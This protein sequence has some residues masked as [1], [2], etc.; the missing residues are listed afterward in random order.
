[1]V[2]VV[3]A[4]AINWDISL[5][6]KRFPEAGEEVEVKEIRRVSGGTAANVAVAA[7]KLLGKGKVA[8]LGALGRDEIAEKQVKILEEWGVV[9]EGLELIGEV[10]S[11]QAYIVIDEKGRNIIH[12]FF[13]A[14]LKF[15][16][17]NV[18]KDKVLKLINDCKVAVIMDPPLVT[19]LELATQARERGKKVIW[20][21]G[22]YV[23]K[24]IK[25]L[26]SVIKKVNYFVLNHL[27]YRRLLNTSSVEEIMN[28]L[29][30]INSEI[31]FI[32]KKGE[33]GASLTD[34][35]TK[36][37]VHVEGLNL[38][39]LGFK[40]V[41]TVGCGDAFIGAF[42]AAKTLDLSDEEALKWGCAA[43]AF[44]ATK[45][46]TRGSPTLKELKKFLK[47]Y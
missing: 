11:G 34:S 35:V 16:P 10:E 42:A 40:I 1:M 14:N 39:K 20:D 15:K 44:K 2:E 18:K 5:F 19:A 24:G 23:E 47:Y 12:T 32:V 17:E 3:S 8:F 25:E 36:E 33:K 41:N 27:E 9:T 22:V 4:G 13:G 7:A 46:E 45:K 43:G 21:P 38:E 29:S 28:K 37:T 31:K 30:R 26:K 6:V